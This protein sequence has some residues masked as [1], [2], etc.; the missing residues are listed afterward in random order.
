MP[1]S[2]PIGAELSLGRVSSG[3]HDFPENEISKL[4]V[5][6]SDLGVVM[7]GHAVLVPCEPLFYRRSDFI[8]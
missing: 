2:F 3:A 1:W 6:V 5:F 8:H 7:L 4:E